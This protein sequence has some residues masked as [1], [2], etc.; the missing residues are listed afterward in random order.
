MSIFDKAQEMKN[1]A[2]AERQ[3]REVEKRSKP[4]LDAEAAAT[5]AEKYPDEAFLSD[6]QGNFDLDKVAVVSPAMG[7]A[8][9]IAALHHG[10][11]IVRG[12]GNLGDEAVKVHEALKLSTERLKGGSS[13]H[14]EEILLCQVEVLNAAFLRYTREA[15]MYPGGDTS[16]KLMT[17]A[18][19]CQD[20]ARKAALALHELRNP[21]KPTQFIKNYVDKQLNAIH[22]SQQPQLEENQNA[23]MDPRSTSTTAGSDRPV[24]AVEVEHRP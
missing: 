15:A 16:A 6:P 3:R 8:T 22:T 13:E 9:A 20:K 10:P 18:L 5:Y 14:L 23:E 12:N 1:R 24:E 7:A 21:K 17:L 2:V 11:S 4:T 19:S